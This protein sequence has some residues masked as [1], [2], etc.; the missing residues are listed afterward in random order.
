MNFIY[1]I[2]ASPSSVLIFRSF[3]LSLSRSLARCI[4]NT[5][6][7]L[8]FWPKSSSADSAHLP[9]TDYT[10]IVLTFWDSMVLWLFFFF[11]NWRHCNFLIFVF[12]PWIID[13]EVS[14][15]IAR[16]FKLC[17]ITIGSAV[18]IGKVHCMFHFWGEGVLCCEDS[19]RWLFRFVA[20]LFEV[21]EVLWILGI[22]FVGEMFAPVADGA[23]EGSG[24]SGSIMIPQRFV[25]PY[26]GR[27]V[28]LSGSF[29]R[30]LVYYNATRRYDTCSSLFSLVDVNMGFYG[31]SLLWC[32]EWD[33]FI[34]DDLY[35][36]CRW[37]DHIA[38]SPMEGCP[39]VFQVVCNLMPGFHQVVLPIWIWLANTRKKSS[40]WLTLLH[41]LL[42]CMYV[43]AWWPLCSKASAS[44]WKISVR[45]WSCKIVFAYL[46][47]KNENQIREVC[48]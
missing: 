12:R 19:R 43:C 10:Q 25:W 28:F 16:D 37:S 4:T 11:F 45:G 47:G 3:S 39:A 32:Q 5:I 21:G 17:V 40:V 14:I 38:M 2:S 36:T 9:L 46:A 18:L 1:L 24:V 34:K 22:G 27:R 23:C 33:W 41:R 7:S 31:F 8:S 15:N 35:C 29:T 44:L 6:V 13:H 20:L 48:L 26:G 30:Y 42:A